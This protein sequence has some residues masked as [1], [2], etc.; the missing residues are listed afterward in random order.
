MD[1]IAPADR[2]VVNIREAAFE[3]FVADGKVVP[4]Q[5]FL[6]LDPSFPPGVGFHIYR[7]EPGSQSQPHEHTAHEQFLV[8]EGELEDHD[9]YVYRTGD[10][11]LL[12]QGTR[13]F[14]RT[15]GGCTVAVFVATAE[16]NL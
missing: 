7:M 9:G 10:L 3:S 14:S 11:V 2:Q 8:L 12:K 16:R 6:Q 5:S 15:R 1:K 4:G 13:H